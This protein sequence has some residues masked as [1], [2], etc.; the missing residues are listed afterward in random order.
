MKPT[1][2]ID[3][4]STIHGYSKGYLD[5][6]IYDEPIDGAKEFIDSI[7][8]EFKIVILTARMINSKD[9]KSTKNDIAKWMKDNDIHFDDIT[10]EKVSA[11][12][13]VDDR[14][15]EFKNDWNHVRDRLNVL[16]KET[17]DELK[18]SEWNEIHNIK[19]RLMEIY[20]DSKLRKRL[21]GI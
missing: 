11:V 5:G 6:T 12:M 3:F 17:K 8:D 9:K 4:D 21:E 20:R 14:A 10:G 15:A 1:V 16:N 18:I 2:C 19:N 13:Y 7:K